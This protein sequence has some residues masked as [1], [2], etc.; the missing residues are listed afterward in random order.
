MTPH[1]RTEIAT[2]AS[3][4][5]QGVVATRMQRE[6][7]ESLAAASGVPPQSSIDSPSSG[8]APMA[9]AGDGKGISMGVA[10]IGNV[11]NREQL[12]ED[13]GWRPADHHW[14]TI[15]ASPWSR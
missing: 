6:L 2:D 4:T 12:W 15:V 5:G 1:H 9:A 8:S 10:D 11:G 7:V 3:S 14:S 13:I